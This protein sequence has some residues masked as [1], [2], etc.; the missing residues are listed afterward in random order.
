MPA[1]A[2]KE[3][4]DAALRQQFGD[5]PNLNPD[6]IFGEVFTCDL[7]GE[8]RVEWEMGGCWV[9]P[10]GGGG[11][12]PRAAT[13]IPHRDRVCVCARCVAPLPLAP[14]AI[15]QN[16]KQRYHRR[17]SSGNWASDKLTDKERKEYAKL[18]V[19]APSGR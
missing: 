5:A 16:R 2:S 15:F 13:N 10:Q 12:L 6:D 3:R 18:K 4:L 1:W 11:P 7:E 9:L 14:S 17:T 19:V 8:F